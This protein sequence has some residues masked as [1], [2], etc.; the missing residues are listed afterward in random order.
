[1][2]GTLG[3][4][5]R[6]RV[7][8]RPLTGQR[9]QGPCYGTLNILSG[10]DTITFSPVKWATYLLTLQIMWAVRVADDKQQG[11][12]LKNA[13]SQY[14]IKY[15]SPPKQLLGRHVWNA[16]WPVLMFCSWWEHFL[17]CLINGTRQSRT[18]VY[19]CINLLLK[20]GLSGC[21]FEIICH[22]I[23]LHAIKKSTTLVKIG[24][25]QIQSRPH[26]MCVCASH[27]CPMLH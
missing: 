15:T 1:M 12:A 3:G 23:Q 7:F 27:T 18:C 11:A 14:T 20:A 26:A 4:R 19:I 13:W 17:R 16:V 9:P 8:D 25:P 21:K 24:I 5:G 10:W 22:T 2:W 6:G